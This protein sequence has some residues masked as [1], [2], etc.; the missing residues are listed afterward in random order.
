MFDSS[1]LIGAERGTLA[2]REMLESLGDEPVAISAVT[3]SELLHGCHRAK[4]VRIRIRRSSYVES[5]LEMIPI[6]PF[7][8]V[9][10]RRHAE[11]W[12]HLASKGTM[13]GAHDLLIAAT[14]LAR[15]YQVATTNRKEFG[16][17]PG[18]V[19]API[20]PFIRK[21]HLKN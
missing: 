17:V 9:E 7:G 8:T 13:I 21:L 3:A 4:E 12:A 11:I 16:R 14:A 2:F 20:G 1:V 19:L 10:A 5:V 15:G 6:V 18:L